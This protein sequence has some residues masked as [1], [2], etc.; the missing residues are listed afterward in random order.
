MKTT[1]GVDLRLFVVL[2]G[3]YLRVGTHVANKQE[4]TTQRGTLIA[5]RGSDVYQAYSAAGIKTGFRFVSSELHVRCMYVCNSA[6][7]QMRC[8]L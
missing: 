5:G 8:G 3:C 2:E 1:L 6:R 4:V 7:D